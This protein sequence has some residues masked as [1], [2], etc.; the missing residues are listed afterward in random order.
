MSKGMTL[1]DRMRLYRV[2]EMLLALV[3]EFR[4]GREVIEAIQKDSNEQ[5]RVLEKMATLENPT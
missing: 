1:D 3:R 5:K 2:E 4:W